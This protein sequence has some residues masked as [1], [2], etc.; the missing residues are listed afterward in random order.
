[1]YMMKLTRSRPDKR[2]RRHPYSRLLSPPS[3]DCTQAVQRPRVP[4]SHRPSSPHVRHEERLHGT[5]TGFAA[6]HTSNTQVYDLAAC[7]FVGV[8]FLY[9]SELM[10]YRTVR[11]REAMIPF[12]NARGGLLWMAL[13]RGSYLG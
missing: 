11:L 2:Q 12:I 7:T 1:M 13:Q 10:I 6:Y 9:G 3:P 5:H 4:R 8:L